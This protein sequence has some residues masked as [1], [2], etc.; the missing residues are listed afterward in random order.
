[1]FRLTFRLALLPLVFLSATLFF[2]RAQTYKVNC[3]RFW[4]QPAQRI[5]EAA[6]LFIARINRKMTSTNN[7]KHQIATACHRRKEA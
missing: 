6:S 3:H 1:M 4:N 2:I 5:L 7:A